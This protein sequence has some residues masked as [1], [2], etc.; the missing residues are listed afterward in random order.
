[1]K[2]KKSL[3]RSQSKTRSAQI[4]VI[5]GPTSSGKTALSV[6]LA[7]KIDGEIISA[8]SRQVYRGL[9][10]GT[11]KVT[12]KEMA[13]VP[14]HLL[15]VASP[16]RVFTADDFVRLGRRAIDD[17][18][19]RGRIPIVA[20]G[21][22]FYID[23]LVGTMAVANVPPD[24]KLRAVL[25]QKSAEQLFALLKK[26]DPARAAT[27]DQ[28]NPHRLIRAIEIAKAQTPR[29]EPSVPEGSPLGA[30]Y[31]I[32]WLGIDMPQEILAQKIHDRLLARLKR[33]MLAEARALHGRGLSWKRME[34]LGL[35][36]R[37]I[38]R[39]LQKK[40]SRE[41]FVTQL[42]AEIRRYA[43]R[44]MTWFKR[45]KEINWIS[46]KTQALSLAHRFLK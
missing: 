43:K 31:D 19:S 39:F 34:T 3:P 9:D 27:I 30:R 22:G 5:V 14:H 24:P 33:G 45:N 6:E 32:L 21:T 37:Y 8:D 20:G 18:L 10:L 7:K 42:E 25:E 2:T 36:Y 17:T 15:D 40:I 11:G 35:E 28:H 44:Q 12:K 26:L 16:A 29:G 38:A 23:T 46:N 13:G 4:I 1:M 41:E